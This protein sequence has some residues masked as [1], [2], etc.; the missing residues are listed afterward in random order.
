MAEA[1]LL[2]RQDAE[3]RANWD[4]FR[5]FRVT[6]VMTMDGHDQLALIDNFTPFTVG[7]LPRHFSKT[8]QI[9]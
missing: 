8:F 9:I 4:A 1:G 3:L 6:K 5:R 2:A 7:E